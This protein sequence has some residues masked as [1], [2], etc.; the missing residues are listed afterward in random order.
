MGFVA[1][2]EKKNHG[3]RKLFTP[4]ARRSFSLSVRNLPTSE[5]L[6][7]T[8]PAVRSPSEG[9]LFG[10]PGQSSYGTKEAKLSGLLTCES[11]ISFTI[12]LPHKTIV[13]KFVAFF[14]NLMFAT[15]VTG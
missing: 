15:V 10:S 4:V 9:I 8:R 3:H 1:P 7:S 13:E 11:L 14:G 2:R 6:Q 12:F 5:E